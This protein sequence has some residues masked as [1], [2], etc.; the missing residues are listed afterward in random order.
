MQIVRKSNV[1]FDRWKD[2]RSAVRVMITKGTYQD[3]AGIHAEQVN[4]PDGLSWSKHRMHG[5]MYGPTGFRRFLPW[6]RAYLV[7]FERSLRQIDKTLALPYW[8][9]DNDQGQLVGFRD[10]LAQSSGRDLGLPP[11]VEATD[12][13]HRPWFSSEALTRFFET[14][15]GDYYF[16]TRTLE[17]GT[18]SR[19][20]LI[21]GQHGA[22]HS[23]IGGDMANTRISPNDIAFWLHHAAIDRLWSKWQSQ[24]PSERAYLS[25]EDAKL[26]PW[27]DEFTVENI[28]DISNLGDDSYSYEDPVRPAPPITPPVI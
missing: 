15:G 14:F 19:L 2:L 3:L 17:V 10:F 26:D 1:T 22:G 16:F 4:D 13:S 21:I 20:G 25:G 18:R 24:N 8:D 27:G 6:H 28:D 5:A 9:W 11:G 12:P 23:W 7:A